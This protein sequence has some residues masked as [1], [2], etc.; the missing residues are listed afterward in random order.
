M[1]RY[2][3][4]DKLLARYKARCLGCRET[5]NYCEH[6]CNIADIISD[7]ED[8]PSE[9]VGPVVRC[10]D[11][12]WNGVREDGDWDYT[13][14]LNPYIPVDGDECAKLFIAPDWYCPEGERRETE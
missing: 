8:A 3:D 9:D 12:K 1:A 13:W 2:I 7:I 6:C 11:C 10:K 4:A 14:C 5:K